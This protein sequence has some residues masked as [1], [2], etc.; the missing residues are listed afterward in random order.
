MM[1]ELRFMV[2]DK[3]VVAISFGTSVQ[4]G[5]S[6]NPSLYVTLDGTR[7]T[8]EDWNPRGRS[9]MQ[10]GET[11]LPVD[12]NYLRFSTLNPKDGEPTRIN[13]VPCLLARENPVAVEQIIANYADNNHPSSWTM[14]VHYNSWFGGPTSFSSCDGRSPLSSV[15]IYQWIDGDWYQIY[16]EWNPAPKSVAEY[17]SELQGE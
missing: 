14:Y 11:W 7:E 12:F 17:F 5:S 16:P 3:D 1:R 9:L 13:T 15:P 6:D 8:F 2:E 10:K 4:G